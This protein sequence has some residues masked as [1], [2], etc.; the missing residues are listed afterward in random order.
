MHGT[1]CGPPKLLPFILSCVSSVRVSVFLVL[2]LG[3][4]TTGS[5]SLAMLS[6]AGLF[7]VGNALEELYSS[8]CVRG[9]NALVSMTFIA[10]L[11]HV[12]VF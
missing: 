4:Q 2:L 10:F 11:N 3:N 8:T 12:D 1:F 5:A 9:E 6:R 7:I